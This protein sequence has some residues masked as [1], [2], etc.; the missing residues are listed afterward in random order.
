MSNLNLSLGNNFYSDVQAVLWK[1]RQ[2]GYTLCSLLIWFYIRLIM[3]IEIRASY[4]AEYGE[5]S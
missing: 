3:R 1:V 2:K 5:D 4:G